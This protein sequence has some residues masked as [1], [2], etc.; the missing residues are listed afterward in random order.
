[1]LVKVQA[2]AKLTPMKSDSRRKTRRPVHHHARVQEAAALYHAPAALA[3][4]PVQA[5]VER[6][7]LR[8][9]TLSRM[10]GFSLRAVAAW[11]GGKMPS[12]PA[13]RVFSEMDR[14]LAG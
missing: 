5:L 9:D 10:T 6:F 3:N 11:A 7:G 8:Q 4:S 2:C 12:A 13:K 14:L 1:M